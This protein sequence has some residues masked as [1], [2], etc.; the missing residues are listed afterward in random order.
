M[1][2]SLAH[3]ELVG[4]L[5]QPFTLEERL[6]HAR[7]ARR[8]LG[9]S[10][11]WLVDAIDNRLKHTLGD[12]P[13]SEFVIDAKGRI[14]VKRAWS[15]P[16]ELR[17]D[18]ERL[19]GPVERITRESE[20]VL[21]FEPPPK[22]PAAQGVVPR[23]K[24][25]RMQAI[26]AEPKIDPKG[27]PF[28]AK[29]RAEA[30][31][32]LIRDGQG[33]LYL[34]FHL[35]PIHGAHWNNLTQ[36]LKF[37]LDLPSGAKFKSDSGTGAVAKATNDVDPREFLIDVENWPEGQPVRLTVTYAACV[38]ESSCHVVRQ[39]YVLHLRRDR[40]GGGA[41]GEGAGYW[42]PAQFVR[43]MM[44]RDKNKDGKLSVREVQGLVR[45][46]FDHF[47]TNKDGL[48]DA[49]ELRAV[50]E[51]LNHHHEPGVPKTKP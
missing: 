4:G 8:R 6:A 9:A 35:D 2:K 22:A 10:I 28:F 48:L 27:Q 34:G 7:E 1:Y 16:G 21:K 36:P 15:H 40:D 26:V 3:P 46:H 43:Q 32:D 12:R 42:E 14:A 5:V 49:K 44:N 39:E 38:G 19:V 33:Q 51:W 13:N 23:L 20:I 37:K 45:P 50:S 29:L 25:P 47:D 24:R 11:P 17:K 30:D 41:R 18:L 31:A